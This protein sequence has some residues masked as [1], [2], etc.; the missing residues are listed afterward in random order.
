MRKR[1]SL[2]YLELYVFYNDTL[3]GCLFHTMDKI[4]D[5]SLHPCKESAYIKPHRIQYCQNGIQKTWDAMTVHDSVA[6]LVFNTTRKVF[7]F[8]K[9]FRPAV[10]MNNVSTQ[11]DSEGNKMVD[12]GKYPGSLGLTLELCAGILDK[13]HSAQETAQA[14]LIEECGYKV[15]L[16]SLQLITSFRGGVATTG[17]K[18]WLFYADVTDAMKVG[19]GGGLE[20][21]GELIEVVDMTVVEGRQLILDESV[22]RPVGMLFALQWFFA[23]KWPRS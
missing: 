8:V 17:S 5:V 2:V 12:T 1:F 14:E 7:V 23:N 13:N 6:I 3:S 15:P 11:T 19:T 20:E 10:Y 22:N 16:D 21:E 18:Q 4:S 9:Q